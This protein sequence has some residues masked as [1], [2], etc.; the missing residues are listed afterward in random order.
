MAF[1]GAAAITLDGAVAALSGV[2]PPFD[3]APDDAIA[4]TGVVSMFF[5]V[6]EV[7]SNGTL[8]AIDGGSG[9]IPEI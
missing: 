6:C 7:S 2:D 4:E 3:D 5:P 8:I 1:D 9:V